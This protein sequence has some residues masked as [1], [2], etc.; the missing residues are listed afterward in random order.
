M[1]TCVKPN[2]EDIA[3]DLVADY[4]SW[5]GISIRNTLGADVFKQTS[6]AIALVP[7]E[8]NF[9]NYSEMKYPLSFFTEKFIRNV[10]SQYNIKSPLHHNGVS[11][12]DAFYWIHAIANATD[13]VDFVKCILGSACLSGRHRARL[14]NNLMFSEFIIRR[15]GVAYLVM[16]TPSE[17]A[18]NMVKDKDEDVDFNNIFTHIHNEVLEEKIQPD[19]FWDFKFQVMVVI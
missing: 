19:D 15:L 12:L 10:P 8:R 2:A 14:F 7:S 6:H 16:F 9:G 13:K 11:I 18:A 17:V 3:K 4:T 5:D 1:S